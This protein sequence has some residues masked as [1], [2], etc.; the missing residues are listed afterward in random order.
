MLQRDFLRCSIFTVLMQIK[1]LIYL[2]STVC[3]LRSVFGISSVC[4]R[5]ACTNMHEKTD[6]V[7]ELYWLRGKCLHIV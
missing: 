4:P 7:V 3:Y 2:E 1:C 6:Y 5:T